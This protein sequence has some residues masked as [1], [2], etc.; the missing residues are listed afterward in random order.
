M[1]QRLDT[2]NEAALNSRLVALR[3]QLVLIWL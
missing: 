2:T 1:R 3:T